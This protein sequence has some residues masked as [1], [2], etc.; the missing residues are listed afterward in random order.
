MELNYA[1]NISERVLARAGGAMHDRRDPGALRHQQQIAFQDDDDGGSGR[2][3]R[4]D[5]A[6]AVSR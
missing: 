5:Q 1:A 2:A 3:P 6:D 4:Y